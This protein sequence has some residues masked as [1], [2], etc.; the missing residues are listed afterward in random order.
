MT[1]SLLWEQMS[2]LYQEKNVQKTKKII[3]WDPAGPPHRELVFIPRLCSNCNISICSEIRMRENDP[4]YLRKNVLS[5]SSKATCLFFNTDAVI[6][7]LSDV[8]IHSNISIPNNF[9]AC[10]YQC[11]WE[12]LMVLTNRV[13]LH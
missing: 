3:R 11:F 9:K 1:D 2:R 4:T 7:R 8:F 6:F 12:C 10:S 5:Q 13:E